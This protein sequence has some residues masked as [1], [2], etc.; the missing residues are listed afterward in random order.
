MRKETERENRMIEEGMYELAADPTKTYHPPAAKGQVP[1]LNF[2]PVQNAFAHLERAAKAYDEAVAARVAK[3]DIPARTAQE[4]NQVLMSTERLMTR[5]GGLPRRPWFRHQIYA[6]GFYTGYGVKTLPGIREAIE[7]RTW[8][9][10]AQQ[11]GYAADALH[12]V[13][14]AIDRATEIVER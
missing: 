8:D 10:A 12:Q 2:A 14:G 4:L 13:A 5:D 9:E 3:G 6:P 11:M 7:Q 1:Y